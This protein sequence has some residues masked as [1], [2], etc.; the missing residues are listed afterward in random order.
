MLTAAER[1]EM[2]NLMSDLS[3]EA[4][5]FRVRKDYTNCSDDEIQADWNYYHETA[6][7]R[8]TE[9]ARQEAAALAE[10]K[11]RINQ[12]CADHGIK[13]H[14]AVKWDMEAM[15]N[16]EDF[17]HYLWKCGIDL[18]LTGELAKVLG[19]KVYGYC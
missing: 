7:R 8:W 5:G 18:R 10:W 2:L 17:E 15:D 13:R 11:A 12:L 19:F 9:E 4:Y 3:K 14:T 1:N 6:T 16:E